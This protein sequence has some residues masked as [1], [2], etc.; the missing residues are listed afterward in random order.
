MAGND[1]SLCHLP[2]GGKGYASSFIPRLSW[3]N[4]SHNAPEPL[5]GVPAALPSHMHR[6]LVTEANG[7][8]CGHQRADNSSLC[9]GPF[10]SE[11]PT[12]A[13]RLKR[14]FVC[15]CVRAVPRPAGRG[16]H[17]APRACCCWQQIKIAVGHSGARSTSIIPQIKASGL[18]PHPSLVPK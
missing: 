5:A 12:R 13:V 15:P 6:K 1:N 3:Q 18:W 16:P 14:P 2:F 7:P 11:P 8:A 4:P 17:A 9:K 10:M